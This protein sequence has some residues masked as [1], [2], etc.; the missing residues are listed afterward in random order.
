VGDAE[1]A[2]LAGLGERVA[3]LSYESSRAELGDVGADAHG[4]VYGT[5]AGNPLALAVKD[6]RPRSTRSAGARA[7]TA[8][9]RPHT[10]VGE[11]KLLR[12]VRHTSK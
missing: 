6:A 1:L 2:A 5:G 7:R 10:V 8:S 3:E 9:A 11:R 4:H 12:P